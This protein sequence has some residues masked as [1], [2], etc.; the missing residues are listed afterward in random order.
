M[1]RLT[2]FIN[3]KVTLSATVLRLYDRTNLNMIIQIGMEKV[4]HHVKDTIYFFFL[5]IR[6]V[7]YKL[8][9]GKIRKI[10]YTVIYLHTFFIE[11]LKGSMT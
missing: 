6:I 2:N 9:G 5:K 8:F 11:A 10:A 7:M 4:C 3:T 1:R